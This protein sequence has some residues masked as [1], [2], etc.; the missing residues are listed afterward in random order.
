MSPIAV[1]LPGAPPDPAKEPGPA[2][3]PQG[4][5]GEGLEGAPCEPAPSC[6]GGGCSLGESRFPFR[7]HPFHGCCWSACP[8]PRVLVSGVRVPFCSRSGENRAVDK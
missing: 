4:V 1:P 7:F 3:W 8:A 5:A 6:A 2:P